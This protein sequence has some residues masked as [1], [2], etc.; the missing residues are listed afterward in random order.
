MVYEYNHNNVDSKCSASLSEDPTSC[1]S[2][3]NNL[4]SNVCYS[5]VH[6]KKLSE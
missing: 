4:F 5:E 2:T 1:G 6:F 3:I